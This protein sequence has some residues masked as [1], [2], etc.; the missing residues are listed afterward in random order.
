MP[1][2]LTFP[3]LFIRGQSPVR[4]RAVVELE[5]RTRTGIWER[6]P[7][8]IDTGADLSS[9]S[10]AHASPPTTAYADGLDL[11]T[12]F[13]PRPVDRR[14]ADGSVRRVEMRL[15]TLTARFAALRA[16]VFRWECLF[17]PTIPP[18]AVPLLGIGGR[19]LTDVS[20]TFRGM[21][22]EH[23]TGSV[24]FDVLASP[25]P[26]FPPSDPLARECRSGSS[27]TVTPPSP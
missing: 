11:A 19:V 18:T 6:V 24:T 23:P 26:L 22:P 13:R 15:G 20:I 3:L 17:D 16:F 7:F 4:R 5:L 9:M 10:L 14:L 12:E 27:V 1:P 8:R 21:S 25:I 2:T